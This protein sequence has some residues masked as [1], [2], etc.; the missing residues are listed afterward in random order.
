MLEG[1]FGATVKA[2]QRDVGKLTKFDEEQ[3]V[4]AIQKTFRKKRERNLLQPE[5]Q[6]SSIVAS[7]GKA[8]DG[9]VVESEEFLEKTGEDL[10]IG[11]VAIQKKEV[12]TAPDAEIVRSGSP[13]SSSADGDSVMSAP[14]E[15]PARIRL[16]NKESEAAKQQKPQQKPVTIL[17]STIVDKELEEKI[18][19]A[20]INP[21][22]LSI[23]AATLATAGYIKAFRGIS[24]R[25][26]GK[27]SVTIGEGQAGDHKSY[28]IKTNGRFGATE[29][30][31]L[32][33]MAEQS[34]GKLGVE[35]NHQRTAAKMTVAPDLTDQ[36]LHEIVDKALTTERTKRA[37]R[38]EG[39]GGRENGK[40]GA[41]RLDGG[42]VTPSASPRPMGSEAVSEKSVEALLVGTR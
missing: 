18:H 31:A 7:L 42:A 3:A 19:E 25:L 20:K 13:D 32:K 34:D 27:F 36:Q 22:I 8:L 10:K 39:S 9:L 26:D 24:G 11:V 17:L 15:F 29:V 14:E 37:E 4:S 40:R 23:S 1:A 2:P 30:A 35:I 16:L 6:I 41:A 21:K 33:A 5:V 28:D 12:R 38:V